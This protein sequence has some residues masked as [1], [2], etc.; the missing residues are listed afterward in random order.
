MG[1]LDDL[2]NSANA[3]YG[4]G[5]I[6]P[7]TGLPKDPPRIPIGVFAADFATAGGVPVYGSLCFW[8]PESAGKSSLALSVAAMSSKI[9]WRCFNLKEWCS[10]SSSPLLMKVFWSDVEGTL[11]RKW[12][13]DIGVDLESFVPNL[14]D[15]GEQYIDIAESALRA[16]DCGLVVMDSLA[17]LTPAA[18]LE[19][20]SIDQFIGNQ[21]K[22]IT[23]AVRLLKQRLIRERKRGHPC[24]VVFTNQMRKK[25]GVMFGNPEEMPGG[26][27]MKHEFSLL[28]RCV[29]KSLSEKDKQKF[30]DS[31]RKQDLAVRHSFSIRKEKVMT[32]SGVGEYVRVR[33]PVPELEL[34]PG[35]VDDFHTVMIYAKE[36]GV[37]EK[38]GKHWRVFDHKATKQESIKTFWKRNPSEYFRVQ[39]EIIKRA[40]MRLGGVE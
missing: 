21:A 9:C 6:F 28:L 7:G 34:L 3:K 23:R 24:C 36:Y 15:Y 10:C 25:I 2:M 17:A 4:E 16:D 12:A 5:T 38:D 32:L 35:M 29:K 1:N 39:K 26:H 13:V 19:A 20:S 8:G 14:S 40:K 37:V 18:E 33:E 31:S 27:G 11:D 22:M 30:V